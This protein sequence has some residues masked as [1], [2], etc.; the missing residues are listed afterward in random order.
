MPA[1]VDSHSASRAPVTAPGTDTRAAAKIDG[2]APGRLT[3]RSAVRRPPPNTC[4]TSRLCRL[5]RLSPNSTL[6]RA[7][8][9]TT[10]VPMTATDAVVP[11][12]VMRMIT[13]AIDTRGIVR[14]SSTSG[15][16]PA[17]T[18][19]DRLNATASTIA[20]IMPTTNPSDESTS[21][22]PT[23]GNSCARFASAFG[24]VKRNSHTSSGP[25]AMYGEIPV[26]L[27]TACHSRS[28]TM[29]VIP[30]L[31]SERSTVLRS[32]RRRSARRRACAAAS[33]ATASWTVAPP[34]VT[35]SRVA[36]GGI[37]PPSQPH[38]RRLRPRG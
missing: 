21:V 10:I 13:G 29:I 23:S 3:L 8:K 17:S 19:F 5:A 38:P 28:S 1:P 7:G 36:R 27:T 22:C 25:F 18:A 31:P 26:R 9:S 35:G 12:P 20:T 2:S 16:T 14:S 6:A 37:R 4:T 24:D 30:A 33:A 15:M 11:R 32:A 34:A